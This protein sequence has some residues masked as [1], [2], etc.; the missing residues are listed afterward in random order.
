[1][2]PYNIINYKELTEFFANHKPA[3][4]RVYDN[5]WLRSLQMNKSF[6]LFFPIILICFYFLI[7]CATSGKDSYIRFENDTGNEIILLSFSEKIKNEIPVVLTPYSQS[8]LYTNS[9]GSGIDIVF[10][11][12]DD[13]Y[14]INTGYAD[15]YQAYTL[16]FSESVTSEN[17]I[18]CFFIAKGFTENEKSP[19][20]ISKIVD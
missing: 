19:R 14:T 12:N 16:R 7:A 15:D 6:L 18:E 2:I 11:Y 3:I 5:L 13:K 1:M 8:K 9:N 20:E 10:S 17:G 4:A